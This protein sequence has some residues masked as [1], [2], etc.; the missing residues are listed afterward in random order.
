MRP[1]VLFVDDEE[2]ILSALTRLFRKED[3]EILTATS[4]IAGLKILEEK[5]VALIISD[6]RMPV[7][8]GVEFLARAKEISPDTIRIML[9]G[10]ADLEAAISAIN[11]G[12][13]YRFISKP[14][15]DEELKLTVRQSLDYR[16]LILKNRSLTRAVKKQYDI[17]KDLER[18]NPGITAVVRSEDGAIFIDEDAD[19][20]IPIEVLLN[21]KKV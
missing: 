3:Y 11:K 12:E 17:L 16:D 8:T 2:N 13:V 15:N 14:W 5:N 21:T 6:H 9:T 18:T 7:M 1:A 20:D 4:G 10:Y 19:M